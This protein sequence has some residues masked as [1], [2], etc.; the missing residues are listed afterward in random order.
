ML[1]E[2]GEEVVMKMVWKVTAFHFTPCIA[3]F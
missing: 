3:M 2:N 1:K